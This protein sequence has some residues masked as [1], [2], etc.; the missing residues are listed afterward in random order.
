MA[1]HKNI[2]SDLGS[3]NLVFFKRKLPTKCESGKMTRAFGSRSST[4]HLVAKKNSSTHL[5]T[6]DFNNIKFKETV[7]REKH[8]ILSHEELLQA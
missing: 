3:A 1:D 6:A 5:R 7:S 4:F 2:D 8:G